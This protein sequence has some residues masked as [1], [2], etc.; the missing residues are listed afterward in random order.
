MSVPVQGGSDARF[1]ALR[2]L[3]T[4]N[5]A[6][7]RE[8]GVSVAV[9]VDGELVADL[10]GGHA[11]PARSRPWGRDTV[12][13]VWSS[14]K[15]VTSLAAL[16]LVDRGE[17]DVDA[18]VARYWPEFAAHGKDGVLV[19]HVLG[20]TSGVSGWD[21]PFALE[22]LY[23]L[24]RS[25]ARLAG[26][27]P[28]WEPGTASGY[29]ANDYGHLVGELVRRTTGMSLREFVRTEIAEPLGAD[30]QIGL[31]ESDDARAAQIVP[32][33]PLPFD[34]AALDPQ[35]VIIKT[36]TSPLFPAETVNTVPWR[37]AE[38]GGVNGHGNAR[39]LC[40][41]LSALALDGVVDGH[42]LLSPA[43]IE[44]VFRE[45][46]RGTDLV[47][48]IPLRWGIGFGLPEPATLPYVPEGRVCFWGGYGGSL[49]V[50]DLDR[51]LTI[52][53]VMNKMNA[54]I[55]GS[56]RSAEYVTA[57]YDALR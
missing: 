14:T 19:R 48:G 2:S 12:V 55:I 52:S 21:Q 43:T 27:A 1:D 8:L 50:V 53:Y 29:H 26:Q 47:L 35:S 18:P 3:L 44:L 39:A 49:N 45:Q 41:I 57:V 23:D 36:F 56:D 51:R 6:A 37:R 38:I 31:R 33:P 32:P 25:T 17:L 10:W 20:N 46:A 16:V 9:D 4:D 5:L 11:D 40:R 22:D 54:G 30:F 42:R 7:D 34:F 13:N 15:T 24:E 28:W